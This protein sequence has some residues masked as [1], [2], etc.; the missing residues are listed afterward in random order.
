MVCSWPWVLAYEMTKSSGTKMS[1]SKKKSPAET[2]AMAM[3]ARRTVPPA[4]FVFLR[5]RPPFDLRL[6]VYTCQRKLELAHE[7]PGGPSCDCSVRCGVVRNGPRVDLLQNED[8][9]QGK[10]RL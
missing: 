1:H 2:E 8:G 7:S 6:A 5:H 9:W 10:Q 4:R 3:Y